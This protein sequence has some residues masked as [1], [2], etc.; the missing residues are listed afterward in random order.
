[1]LRILRDA[2]RWVLLA[3]LVF[4]P[5][6]YGSTSERG[7]NVLT[8]SL[9]AVLVLWIASIAF[10]LLRRSER[11]QRRPI[12][13]R[14][15][16]IA[17]VALLVLGWWMALNAPSIYDG[18]FAI[19]VDL[20]SLAPTVPGSVDQAISVAWMW[21]AT[22]LIGAL[23]IAADACRDPAWLM[24]I[25]TTAGA[26]GGS[27]ALLG[28]VQ[29]ATHAPM[30]FWRNVDQPVTTFF[31]TFFYHGNAGAFLNLTLPVTIGLAI[32]AFSLR[33]APLSRAL[34]LSLAIVSV[35][36]TFANTS[37][38][39]HAVALLILLVIGAVL[40]LRMRR[41][42]R[43]L[44]WSAVALG[45]LTVLLAGYAMMRSVDVERSIGRWDRASEIIPSD[46]RWL[47]AKTAVSASPE[48]GCFGFGPGTF[49]VVFPY[50]T[51]ASGNERLR[52]FWRYL[53]QDYLQTLLEWGWIGAA[54]MGFVFF[55]GLAVALTSRSGG[56]AQRWKPRQ[57]ILLPLIVLALVG[58]ALHAAVDFPLQIA[59]IQLYVAVYVG[60]CWS[61]TEWGREA[62]RRQRGGA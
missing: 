2:P 51:G 53:H 41:T 47:A 32:R 25:C 23:G 12:L 26:T 21:R 6:F 15:V 1:V 59:S 16:V 9:C 54:L 4:A 11:E 31:A 60:I 19:F 37:R 5:W 24:R 36:A 48:A 7:T 35:I 39:G 34:W 49:H 50:L 13:L 3:A 10:Q 42:S 33:D 45:L 52:G 38:M 44:T 61:A 56:R 27:I 43:R 29:K 40:L 14:L 22:A 58:V 8:C 17:A 57:Q 28:L 55:G 18:E 62:S 46:A 30:I 20:R